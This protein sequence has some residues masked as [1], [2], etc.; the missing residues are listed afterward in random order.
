MLNSSPIAYNRI[1]AYAGGIPW[2]DTTDYTVLRN[3]PSIEGVTLNG[4]KTFVQLGLIPLTNAEIDTLAGLTASNI[5]TVYGDIQDVQVNNIS[6]VDSTSK[7]AKIDLTNYATW[8]AVSD[9]ITLAI[10]TLAD[11]KQD[12]LTAGNNITIAQDGTISATDTVYDDT[13]VK[14]RLTNLESLTGRLGTS[15]EEKQDILTAGTNITISNNTISATDTTYSAFVGATTTN[16]GEAGL[17]PAP[18]AGNSDRYLCSDGT[19]KT[20]QGGGGASAL[21]DLTDV[22][23][24]SQTLADG[25]VLKYNST[26]QQWENGVGGGGGSTVTITPVSLA[27]SVATKIADYSIDGTSGVLNVPKVEYTETSGLTNAQTTGTLKVGNTSYSIRASVKAVNTYISNSSTTD[28]TLSKAFGYI[29]I[30][31][32]TSNRPSNISYG[33][34]LYLGGDIDARASELAIVNTSTVTTQ[35]MP[36]AYIRS[37]VGSTWGS[38][39]RLLRLSSAGTTD[40]TAQRVL[41]TFS[42]GV[43]TTT[44]CTTTEVNYLSG[45]TSNVQTQLDSKSTVVAN[46]STS[47]TQDLSK[48]TIDGTTYNVSSG[49]GTPTIVSGYERT[50]LYTGPSTYSG[51]SVGELQLSDSISNY[52]EI[53]IVSQDTTVYEV[54]HKFSTTFFANEFPYTDSPNQNTTPHALISPYNNRFCRV[55]MGSTNNKIYMWQLANGYIRYIYGIKYSTTANQTIVSTN[56]PTSS[57]GVVGD[58]FIQTDVTETTVIAKYV[59]INST[60]WVQE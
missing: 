31:T 20:V 19:W 15:I 5:I 49:G 38:W 9:A 18:A 14:R 25:D 55:V 47:A 16:H 58:R 11:M 52:D 35:S 6:V 7:I 56:A 40:P 60:T 36:Q 8:S 51:A 4:N 10:N 21:D 42:G 34:L 48:V 33:G 57:D 54:T 13:V 30:T 43:V 1:I 32:S 12:V 3:K 50:L 22:V 46:P 27:S 53:E 41:A 37:K 24:D 44:N 26:T 59:K 28:I 39:Y 23:I 2:V 29:P 17:V 45:V